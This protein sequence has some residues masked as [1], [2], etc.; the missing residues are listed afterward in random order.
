[1]PSTHLMEKTKINYHV[2]S[3]LIDKLESDGYVKKE[4]KIIGRRKILVSLTEKGR[5]VAEKLLE[6]EAVAKGYDAVMT[7]NWRDRFKGMRAFAHMNIHENIIRVWDITPERE[8]IAEVEI[9]IR[10]NRM[11]LYCTLC[12]STSCEHIDYIF[13]NPYLRH[14]IFEKAEIEGLRVAEPKEKSG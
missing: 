4:E 3:K 13:S 10:G 8:R 5:V 12:N 11:M 9:R 6:A 2:L 1:M 7:P 14:L